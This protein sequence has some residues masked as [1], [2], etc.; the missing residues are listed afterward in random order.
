MY[1]N[2]W[3]ISNIIEPRN[4]YSIRCI[5][6]SALR[7]TLKSIDGQSID[8][9]LNIYSAL[10]CRIRTAICGF[11]NWALLASNSLFRIISALICF[12]ARLALVTW[13]ANKKINKIYSDEI[14]H[15]Y[16]D[17]SPAYL[18]DWH[19]K[20]LAN[21]KFIRNLRNIIWWSHSCVCNIF[22]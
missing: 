10:H 2:S 1:S 19:S 4:K 11:S 17:S 8:V 9:I 5:R 3:H 18:D 20:H 7:I 16:V 21:E 13:S 12:C 22:I 14:K 6:R 15:A